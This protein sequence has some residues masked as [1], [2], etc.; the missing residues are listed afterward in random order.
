MVHPKT[1]RTLVIVKP[2]GV[3]RSL[4]GEMI[5]RY[6]RIGLK[7]V[8]IKMLI[9][10]EDLVERHYLADPNWRMT[11]GV[12]TLA[13]YEKKGETP[14]SNDPLV[15]GETILQM[16]KNYMTSGPVIPMVWEGVHAVEV[17]KKI[18]GGTEPRTSD[19]GTIRGDFM[20]DSYP[21]SDGDKRA[22]RNLVHI[23][24]KVEDA[25]TEIQVW[26]PPEE[27]LDYKHIQERILYD[28]DMGGILS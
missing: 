25:V 22:I 17:V 28:L 9:P 24:G 1:E 7:L 8:A 2:D 14:P 3:Q 20:L 4:V 5:S 21:L 18:T 12:K 13:A 10:T 16:V 6:E 26:F 19:I 15:I 27:L 23:S 11:V